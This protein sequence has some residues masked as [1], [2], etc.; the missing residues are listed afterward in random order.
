M[1]N[2]DF[3]EQ[4]NRDSGA[5]PFAYLSTQRPEQGLNALPSDTAAD[6]PLED[7]LQCFEVFYFHA[8]IVPQNGTVSR[9]K[10]DRP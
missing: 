1:E 6:G 7:A 5:L 8:Y 3:T 10:R 2:S 4:K 9:Y